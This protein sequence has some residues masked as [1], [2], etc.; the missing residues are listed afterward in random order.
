MTETALIYSEGELGEI[1]GKVA[2]GLVRRSDKFI[3]LGVIDSSKAPADAGE[4]LDGVKNGIRVFES[5]LTAIEHIGSI[6]KYFI[7]GIAP[8]DPV[9][10][11][12]QKGVV[13]SAMKMGMNI[14]NGLP[15][16]FSDDP[17]FV[18]EAIKSE[19]TIQDF[20]KPPSRKD[21]HCF[22][23]SIRELETPVV[24]VLGTD[25]AVGKR[26]TA[27]QLV[28]ELNQKGIRAIFI[29]TGQTGLIQG[30]KYGVPV[31]M[32]SSG[33]ASGEIEHAILKADAEDEPEIIVV[34]GQGSLS[35]PAFTSTSAILKGAYPRAVIIQDAPRR[36]F[37]CDYP[38]IPLPAVDEEIELIESFCDTEV[39]AITLNHELMTKD[40][41][42]SAISDYEQIF[43]LPTC[44]VL[45][46]GCDKLI[47]A[48]AHRFPKLEKHIS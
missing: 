20:R 15:E 10:T 26:T 22:T 7:Y 25:C 39:I 43:I 45:V 42:K 2:N 23:G 12:G 46:D 17:E 33:F 35:H 13:I 36:K 29:A 44:D 40:E 9:L 30:S 6:P 34:E 19:V 21:L 48:L 4:L 47:S 16:Y 11:K 24:A 18:S 14:V 32:L 3:I 37:H 5:I 41:L 1:D 38:E 27:F 8:L 31:D 28:E